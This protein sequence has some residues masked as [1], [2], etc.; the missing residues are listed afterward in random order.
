MHILIVEGNP[1]LGRLWQRHLMRCGADVHL[2]AAQDEAVSCLERSAFD[3]IVLNLVLDSGSAF[4]VADYAA[5]RRPQSKVVFVSNSTF[6]SDGSIFQH[7]PNACAFLTTTTPPDDLA[8]VVEHY[9][10]AP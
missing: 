8:A 10:T 6:F 9:A 5:Y 1:A 4:A 2:V 7:I 3:V